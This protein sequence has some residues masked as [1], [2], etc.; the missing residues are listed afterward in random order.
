MV[1]EGVGGGDI[2]AGGGGGTIGSRGAT[3]RDYGRNMEKG[4][5]CSEV[6]C[7]GREILISER[8]ECQLWR[9]EN[10]EK[11]LFFYVHQSF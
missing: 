11:R 2:H 9:L 5:Q 1:V 8:F 4:A 3:W 10:L 7:G 6:G